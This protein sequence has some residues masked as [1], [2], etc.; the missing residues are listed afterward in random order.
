MSMQGMEYD[1]VY[2]LKKKRED[3]EKES[4]LEYKQI[5]NSIGSEDY[6]DKFVTRSEK[7]KEQ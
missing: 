4:Q 3:L 7:Y 2:S 6:L 5:Y 1:A